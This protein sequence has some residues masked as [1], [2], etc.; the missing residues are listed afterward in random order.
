[1]NTQKPE[2]MLCALMAYGLSAATIAETLYS[3]EAQNDAIDLVT[4][5]GC[6]K[7]ESGNLPW[8]LERATEGDSTETAYTDR[9]ELERSANEALGRLSYRL[10]GVGEFVI[11]PHLGHKVQVKGIK[12]QY[13][14]E[15]RLNVT[16][17]QHLSPDCG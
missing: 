14:G 5:V 17:F 1:M 13:E 2:W 6:L 3:E 8:I 16:S 10:I 15:W 4:V 7:E 9:D 11:D 12:L